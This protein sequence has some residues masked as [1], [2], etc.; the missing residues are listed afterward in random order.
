MTMSPTSPHSTDLL[1]AAATNSPPISFA[2]RAV[3]GGAA[4]TIIS[5]LLVST[6]AQTQAA[7][8]AHGMGAAPPT[9]AVAPAA[10]VRAR[11]PAAGRS[12]GLRTFNW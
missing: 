5:A 2:K 8:P 3:A 12:L 6:A 1:K 9:R 4:L 10:T 7:T 11:A